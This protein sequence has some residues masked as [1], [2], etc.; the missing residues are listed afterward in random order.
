MHSLGEIPPEPCSASADGPLLTYPPELIPFCIC[1]SLASLWF[2]WDWS[3]I[4]NCCSSWICYKV[5]KKQ[6]RVA[7]INMEVDALALSHN[8]LHCTCTCTIAFWIS[9]AFR[10]VVERI[11][12]PPMNTENLT[13]I[14]SCMHFVPW[15]SPE[16]TNN[17]VQCTDLY[18]CVCSTTG[19]G[20]GSGYKALAM[21]VQESFC[22]REKGSCYSITIAFRITW[23]RNWTHWHR[24]SFNFPHKF[25]LLFQINKRISWLCAPRTILTTH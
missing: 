17:I 4:R 3:S 24:W 16:H 20:T 23:V 8:Q 21:Y 9:I 5:K 13:V 18:F 15:L 6:N 14:V 25:F 12:G 2:N 22:Q 19:R 7:L 11:Y 10:I 1:F